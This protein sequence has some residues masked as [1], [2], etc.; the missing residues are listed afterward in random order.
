VTTPGR[1]IIGGVW[2]A[3]LTG[4]PTFCHL[5]DI[6]KSPFL[7]P[8]AV[9]VQYSIPVW[10]QKPAPTLRIVRTS[11]ELI[12]MRRKQVTEEWAVQRLSLHLSDMEMIASSL[13]QPPR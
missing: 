13:V 9:H 10:C 2:N 4:D 3:V 8:T 5:D 6:S 12:R 11:M 1:P 7:I